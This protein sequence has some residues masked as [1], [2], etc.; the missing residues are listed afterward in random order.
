MYGAI[1]KNLENREKPIDVIVVGVGFMGFGFISGQLNIPGVRVP[2]VISRRPKA[3]AKYLREHGLKARVEN[4]LDRINK[5]KEKNIISV[6]NDLDLVTDLKADVVL[7]MTGTIPYGTEVALIALNSKKHLVTMNPELQEVVGTELKKIADKNGVIITDVLGDQPGSL[8]RLVNHAKLMGFKV[9]VA[10]NMKRYMDRHATQQQ[11]EP[12]AKDKGLAVRQT[13]SFT[14]GTKQSIEMSLVSNYFGM[15]ILEF[16]MRGPQVDDINEALDKFDWKKIGENGIADYVIGRKLFPGIFIVAEHTDPNQ[17]KYLRYL[18]LG[19]GPRYVLFEPYH[20]CHLEVVETIAD[21]VINNQETI[22]NSLH[23]NTQTIAVAKFDLKKGTKLD[24]IGGDTA[25]GNIDKI[26]SA[27]GYLQIGL[28]A[29]AI[30]VNDLHQDQPIKLSDVILPVNAATK[31]LGLTK[32]P[33][34]RPVKKSILRPFN[35]LPA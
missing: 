28:S 5:N 21:V 4:K 9:L 27:D 17:T 29:G 24:G 11:M 6:S 3:A 16:G 7:E 14:D 18:S 32:D 26:E 23:P 13:V 2:L 33:I 20:L 35:F 22:N 15:D 30:L 10:G 31:L 8:A 25:Y 34:K 12:W 19:D 1:L